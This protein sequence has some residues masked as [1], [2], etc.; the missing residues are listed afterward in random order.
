MKLWFLSECPTCE[1]NVSGMPSEMTQS[2]SMDRD[3]KNLLKSS[4]LYEA[5]VCVCVCVFTL[6]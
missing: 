1:F 5:T 6:A 3:L 4:A 2:G